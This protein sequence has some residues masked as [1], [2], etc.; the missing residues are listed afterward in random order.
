MPMDYELVLSSLPSTDKIGIIDKMFSEIKDN[1][2]YIICDCPPNLYLLTRNGLFASD[3][4][5]I[6]VIPDYLSSVGI[7]ELIT[8]I[9]SMSQAIVKRIP[10][11]GIIFTKVRPGPYYT[12]TQGRH[13]QSIR[14]NVELKKRGIECFENPIFEREDVRR[15]LDERIPVCVFDPFSTSAQEFK[16]LT[17]WFIGRV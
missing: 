2:D 4:Y 11:K 10:C 9:E 13:M 3:S 17:K 16:D 14:Q 7:M 15:A 8:R 6:P 12:I 1:Y 5:I